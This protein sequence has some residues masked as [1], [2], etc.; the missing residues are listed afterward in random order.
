MSD[1]RFTSK[2]SWS[3]PVLASVAEQAGLSQSDLFWL[4][5]LSRPVWVKS[6]LFWLL[7]W[8][9]RFELV[10]P[11]LASVADQAGLSQSCLFWPL[12][13]SRP[14]WVSLT[15]PGYCG[16]AG[17]FQS[18]LPVLAT[19]AEQASLSQSS[20]LVLVCCK[21]IAVFQSINFQTLS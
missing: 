15:C 5:W 9:G 17:Q 8:A 10:L 18:V 3:W 13:L 20:V 16:W 11:V 1:C 21:E 14:V 7:C 2:L 6:C 19:V 12:W 4:L